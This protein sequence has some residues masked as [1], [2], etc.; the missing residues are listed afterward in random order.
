[1]NSKRAMQG[2]IDKAIKLLMRYKVRQPYILYIN[3]NYPD[4]F[5]K[6]AKE[7]YEKIGVE[8]KIGKGY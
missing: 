7:N 6:K 8:V 5:I 3:E 4:S 2:I 1:M